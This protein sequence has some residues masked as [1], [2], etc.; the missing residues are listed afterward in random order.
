MIDVRPLQLKKDQLV[1][2]HK[3]EEKRRLAIDLNES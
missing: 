2:S 1:K 3:D